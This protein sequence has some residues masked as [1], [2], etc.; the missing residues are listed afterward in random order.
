VKTPSALAGLESRLKALVQQRLAR[1]R[2]E[3][4]VA[5]ETT[6]P[7]ERDVVLDE[8]LLERVASALGTARRRGLL[9]GELTASDLLRIPQALEIRPRTLPADASSPV[10]RLAEIMDSV[11][12]EA[13]D[14]LV[15]MR[16]TE[17]RIIDA[18]LQERLRT[19]GAYADTLERESRD[20]QRLL[21]TRL[22][23]RMET[24]PAD[25]RGDAAA[26]AR[27]IIRFVARSDVDEEVVRLRGHVEHA[28]VL[29]NGPEPC[30]RKLDFLTQ[31]MH[32]EVNTIGSKVESLQATET[33][34]AAKAEL[35]RIRE[36]VQNVE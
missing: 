9:T 3:L 7:I 4:T 19:I 15:T 5:A 24:L 30:G 27:E 2:V 31:E 14:G 35:E 6:T 20:G 32:R 22:R 8:Q 10:D 16:E 36:Q 23:E 18:D 25:V 28:G 12:A 1:G 17:G 33:V 11:V 13:I 29:V 21:E 34:I 26:V